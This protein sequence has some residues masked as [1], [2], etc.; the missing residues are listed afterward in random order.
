LIIRDPPSAPRHEQHLNATH[1]PNY[2][3]PVI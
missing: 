1:P 2:M 3:N